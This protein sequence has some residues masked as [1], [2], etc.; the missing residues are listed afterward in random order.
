MHNLLAQFEQMEGNPIVLQDL[1]RQ[2]SKQ[3][4]LC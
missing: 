1:T 2:L 4:F 3:Q